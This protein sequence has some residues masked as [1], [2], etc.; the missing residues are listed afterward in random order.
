MSLRATVQRSSISR[1]IPCPSAPPLV[2][3]H[4]RDLLAATRDLFDELDPLAEE[5]GEVSSIFKR[6]DASLCGRIV[7]PYT[8]GQALD[9]FLPAGHFANGAAEVL[10]LGAGGSSLALV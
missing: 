9:L 4:K 6:D 3:T 10:V 2:T 1:V 8:G 7:D 5:M